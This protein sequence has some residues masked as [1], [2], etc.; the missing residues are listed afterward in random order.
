MERETCFSFLKDFKFFFYIQ[1]KWWESWTFLW[2]VKLLN[3]VNLHFNN[4]KAFHFTFELLVLK[5]N[6][7]FKKVF[8]NHCLLKN[9]KRIFWHFQ[10]KK[11]KVKLK[12]S[13]DYIC[14]LGKIFSIP[15]KGLF[16]TEKCPFSTQLHIAQGSISRCDSFPFFC[17][18]LEGRGYSFWSLKLNLKRKSKGATTITRCEKF[19]SSI[20]IIHFVFFCLLLSKR[21]WGLIC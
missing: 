20:Q 7:H 11:I 17:S 2:L 4:G 6:M 3:Y 21:R 18:C 1:I 10:N 16:S 19:L 8:L 14:S 5:L 12:L 13:K 15:I 9:E